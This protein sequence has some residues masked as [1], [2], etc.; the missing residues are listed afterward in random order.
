ME[1]SNE[2]YKY[3][4]LDIDGQLQFVSLAPG[5]DPTRYHSVDPEEANEIDEPCV[6]SIMEK[7]PKA[8]RGGSRSKS[9]KRNATQ[10]SI[11]ASEGDNSEQKKLPKK[12]ILRKKKSPRAK[13]ISPRGTK[14]KNSKS[15]SK[16]S[17][18]KKTSSKARIEQS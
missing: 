4:S 17:L 8:S 12:K 3:P 5:E 10:S 16:K 9:S 18:K 2:K 14:P 13:A 6:N 11:A 15:P 1:S 7:E